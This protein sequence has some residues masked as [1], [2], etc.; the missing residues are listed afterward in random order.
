MNHIEHTEQVS[1]MKW[2]SLACKSFGI[3]EQLL[4]AIPNGGHRNIVTATKLKA[5]GVRAG[6]PDLFLAYPTPHGGRGLFIE[7]KKAKGGR[8]SNDQGVMIFNLANVGYHCVVCHGWVEAKD[9]IERYMQGNYIGLHGP[10][11]AH[12]N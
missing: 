11:K 1:L 2:W 12:L 5:E 6:V 8:V 9:A 4:F 3:P 7:M 10:Q